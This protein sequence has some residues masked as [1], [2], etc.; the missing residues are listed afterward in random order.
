MGE[1]KPRAVEREIKQYAALEMS[2]SLNENNQISSQ[3]NI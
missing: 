1:W 2:L 3:N